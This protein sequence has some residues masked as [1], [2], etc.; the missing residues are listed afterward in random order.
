MTA[1]LVGD[2]LVKYLG[3]YTEREDIV[4]RSLSG[5]KVADVPDLLWDIERFK[6]VIVHVGINDLAYMPRAPRQV[7]DDFIKL[8]GCLRER[9]PRYVISSPV[10]HNPIFACKLPAFELT[11]QCII[12]HSP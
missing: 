12:T 9:N 4:T 10:I 5:A 2:S 3:R 8:L 6:F 7:L 11:S 1:I